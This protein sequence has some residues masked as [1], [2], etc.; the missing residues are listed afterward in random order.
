MKWHNALVFVLSLAVGPA[1]AQEHDHAAHA[2]AGATKAKPEPKVQ[3][4]TMQ[5][6][7]MQNGMMHDGMMKGMMGM[8]VVP[9]TVTALNPKSGLVDG[10]SGAMALKLHFPSASLAGVKV[11]DKLSVHMGFSR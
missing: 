7:M 1:L 5:G 2:A 9:I 11:G 4:G 6:G 3:G 10:T 8:H